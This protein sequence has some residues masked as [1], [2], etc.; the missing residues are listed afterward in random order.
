[1]AKKKS[2]KKSLDLSFVVNLVVILL[3]VLT[4][5]TLFMP[6]FKL[7][8]VVGDLLDHSI[9]GSDVISGAFASE[10]TKDMTAGAGTIY[11][12]RNT[13]EISFITNVFSWGYIITLVLACASIVFA[14]LRILN[15]KFKMANVI[16]GGLLALVAVV[17]FIF[18][19]V[20]SS[21]YASL[22]TILG[23]VT[24]KAIMNIAVYLLILTLVGGLGQVYSATRK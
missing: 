8:T 17:T 13:E 11:T 21:K 16:I 24:S 5:C 14:V 23:N 2:S 6:V 1:M 19:I 20:L 4:I 15:M 22:N 9:K 18:A 12:L 7:D 10:V 3:G